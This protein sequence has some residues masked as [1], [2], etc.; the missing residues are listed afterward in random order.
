MHRPDVGFP[1]PVRETVEGAAR[2][3]VT[4]IPRRKG[5]GSKGPWPFY[6]PSM[7][8]N[9]DMS[10]IVL[11][12]WPTRIGSALDGLA[13]SGAWGIRMALEADLPDVTLNDR[14]S[15]ATDLARENVRRNGIAATLTTR[16]LAAQL[17][18]GSYD[19]VDIDPFGPPTPFLDAALES[20]RLG[21]GLGIT[22]T[23]TA[24]LCGTYPEA[25]LRRYGARPLRCD[26]GAEIGVRVLLGYS[27]KVAQG[28]EKA[29]DPIVSFAA[30]HFIRLIVRV[31][32]IEKRTRT[33]WLE[34]LGPGEFR[35]RHRPNPD[36]IGPLWMG[37]AWDADLVRRLTPSSWTPGT[38]ARLLSTI[39]AEVGLPPWFVT[40]D[41]L[42]ARERGSPPKLD[43]FLEGLRQIGYRAARTHFHPRGVRT[44]APYADLI[45]VFRERMPSGSTDGSEPA[46]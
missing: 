42:A 28:H 21:S 23:D 18:S 33:G 11:Q 30:A 6:N 24:V 40:T 38:T 16:D 22:A 32:S 44:D 41:E 36:S 4:D 26:Q 34:R 31:R 19:F 5:P 1:F 7:A 45:R 10:A 12:R 27:A 43:R 2:L 15:A 46:S 17:R 3:L 37:A 39:Q 13:A 25:C 14:S 20:A 35:V 8:V 9:R 29:I